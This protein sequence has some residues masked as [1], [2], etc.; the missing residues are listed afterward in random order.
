MNS[1]T[2]ATDGKNS[3]AA[4]KKHLLNID[5]KSRF[6]ASLGNRANTFMASIINITANNDKL[7][8]ATPDSIMSAAFI[9]AALDLPIEPNLGYAAIIPY[10]DK[11]QFQIMYKGIIQLAIRSGQYKS[12]H[13]SAI[14][15]DELVSYDPV[16]GDL[17]FSDLGIRKQ[18]TIGD[19]SKIVGYYSKFE[20][21]T[22]FRKEFYMTLDEVRN[23]AKKY[24]AAYKY[25]IKFKKSSSIWSTDFTVMALKTVIKLSLQ[26][27]GILSVQLQN[28]IKY[29]QSVVSQSEQPTYVD[30]LKQVGS[31]DGQKTTPASSL[32]KTKITKET[33]S[34]DNNVMQGERFKQFEKHLGEDYQNM[35][36]SFG[37]DYPSDMPPDKQDELYKAAMNFAELKLHLSKTDMEEK[38]KQWNVDIKKQ[39]QPH[40]KSHYGTTEWNKLNLEQRSLV[41]KEIVLVGAGSEKAKKL[42]IGG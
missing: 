22:G 12:I 42:G 11:A 36:A 13:A 24:S 33:S 35:V 17:E 23:H 3:L 18:R 30:N 16:T 8:V 10:K 32:D 38:A 19:E 25:D 5:I 40:M 41:N 6:Q 21:I 20:L 31:D 15:E 29:D 26:R 4:I 39:I 7:Q 9:A 14:Y 2:P 27:W 37:F 28:A 1:L 34:S